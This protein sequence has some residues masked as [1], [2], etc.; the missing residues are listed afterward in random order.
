MGYGYS[1]LPFFC[2]MPILEIS[3]SRKFQQ[4]QS[5]DEPIPGYRLIRFLGQGNFGEVWMASA[6][7]NKKVAL[8]IID[9]RGREGLLESKAIER[10]KDINHAHLVSIFAYWLVDSD[11]QILDDDADLQ[12]FRRPFGGEGAFACRSA[13][14]CTSNPCRRSAARRLDRGHDPGVEEPFRPAGRIPPTRADRLF[15][16][17]CFWT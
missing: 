6:P 1:E 2:P 11:G 5:G 9:L 8:K 10:I 3:M 15:R 7:G 13:E 12:A 14:P 4:Y 16:S 17:M